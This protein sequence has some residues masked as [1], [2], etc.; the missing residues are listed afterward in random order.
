MS[1]LQQSIERRRAADGYVPNP[2]YGTKDRAMSLQVE[3]SAGSLW[4][5]PWNHFTFGRHEPGQRDRLTLTFVAYEVVV[6]GT[7]LGELFSE[8]ATH[9][10]EWLRAVPGKYLKAAPD[11]PAIASIEVR[12]LREP[13]VSE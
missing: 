5:L 7:K 2:F 11:E 4:M 6:R 8:V 1:S 13:V 3:D 10:L 9:R 12:S